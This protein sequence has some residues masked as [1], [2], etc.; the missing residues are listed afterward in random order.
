AS[1]GQDRFLLLAYA[2]KLRSDASH[3]QSI[4]LLAGDDVVARIGSRE[5][6]ALTFNVPARNRGQAMVDVPSTNGTH[7]ASISAVQIYVK[8][9]PP[10]HAVVPLNEAS[11]AA[12]GPGRMDGRRGPFAGQGGSG[13]A[14]R[15]EAHQE[16]GTR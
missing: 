9:K 11:E 15:L 7:R 1:I 3:V 4:D 14:Q 12:L 2:S 6:H 5:A 13:A 8:S 10:S 16:R